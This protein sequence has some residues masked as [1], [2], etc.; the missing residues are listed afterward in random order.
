M[1]TTLKIIV[2]LIVLA[3]PLAFRWGRRYFS[4]RNVERRAQNLP[5]THNAWCEPDGLIIVHIPHSVVGPLRKLALMAVDEENARLIRTLC[6][7]MDEK[8]KNERCGIPIEDF[9]HVLSAVTGTLG[10]FRNDRQAKKEYDRIND[11]PSVGFREW[12]KQ[13][14]SFLDAYGL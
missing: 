8:D 9:Y 10:Q 13:L 14:D 1:D 12:V 4:N 5:E 2:T 6:D 11:D 7:L 3:A